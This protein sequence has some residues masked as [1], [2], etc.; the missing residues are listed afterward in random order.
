MRLEDV[1]LGPAGGSGDPLLKAKAI[2]ADVE[3]LPLVMT[4]FKRIE[5][6]RLRV[7]DPTIVLEP[8]PVR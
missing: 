1:T 6:G 3:A 2:E 5:V 4:L 7:E 8:A